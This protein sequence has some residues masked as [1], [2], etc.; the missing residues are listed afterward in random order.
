MSETDV[1]VKPVSFIESLKERRVPQ[2]TGIYIGASWG[3]IQFIEWLVERYGLSPYLPD[4]S[5]VILFSLIPTVV[6]ISYFHG[7]P[8]PDKWTKFEIITSN[9]HVACL[10]M[11][12]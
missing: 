2:I 4:F 5:L 10:F 11:S 9:E 1:M 3:L 6:V 8:G 7:R 12:N